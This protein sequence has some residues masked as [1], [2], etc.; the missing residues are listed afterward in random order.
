M[1]KYEHSGDLFEDLKEWLGCQFI[2]DINSEEFQCE[3]CWALISPIF[4]GYTLEQSQDMM[5]Y[6]SLNQYTQ[7]TNEN[8][9]KSILQQ[10]LVER[11]NFSEG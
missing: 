8:E 4:T 10:H 2:S 6:L 3:A 1:S 5:E 11:R 9:A 7:I